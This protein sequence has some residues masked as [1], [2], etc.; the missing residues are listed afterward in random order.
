MTEI[1]KYNE[2]Y[3]LNINIR[4]IEIRKPLYIEQPGQIEY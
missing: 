4:C 2:K 1:L 3:E